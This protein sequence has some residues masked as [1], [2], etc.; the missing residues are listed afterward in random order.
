MAV[1]QTPLA[2][3]PSL[4]DGR[5]LY[6]DR[7]FEIG[8]V[9]VL[10]PDTGTDRVMHAG[11]AVVAGYVVIDPGAPLDAVPEGPS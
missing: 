4:F 10:P 3:A 1:D 9:T 5:C 11:C 7:R 2:A 6:C 8:E